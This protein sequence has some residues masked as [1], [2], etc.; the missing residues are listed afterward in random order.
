[1][2]DDLVDRDRS[3]LGAGLLPATQAELDELALQR[4]A[5]TGRPVVVATFTGADTMSVYDVVE[6]DLELAGRVLLEAPTPSLAL[7]VVDEPED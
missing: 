7:D 5:A 2:D 4:A 6:G 3:E 1:M